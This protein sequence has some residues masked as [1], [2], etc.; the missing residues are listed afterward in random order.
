MAKYYCLNSQ[1]FD[2]DPRRYVSLGE[3]MIEWILQDFLNS[4]NNLFA[5]IFNINISF[6]IF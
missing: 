3:L 4:F 2:P 5:Q 6:F 1:E